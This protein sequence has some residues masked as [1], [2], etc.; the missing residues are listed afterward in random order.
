[1]SQ[2]IQLQLRLDRNYELALAKRDLAE[3]HGTRGAAGVENMV[4][5]K[6]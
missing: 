5:F 4:G 1:M 2:M 3:L 6:L